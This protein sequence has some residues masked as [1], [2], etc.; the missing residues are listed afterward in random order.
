MRKDHEI[1]SGNVFADLGLPNPEQ[2]LV[3]AKLTMQIFRRTSC[4]AVRPPFPSAA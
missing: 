1:S 4:A 2:E 3:K